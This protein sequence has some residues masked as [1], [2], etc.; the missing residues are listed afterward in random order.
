MSYKLLLLIAMFTPM[1]LVAAGRWTHVVERSK[2]QDRA[3][4]LSR[5]ER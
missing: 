4:P 5:P 1:L 3:R 2:L